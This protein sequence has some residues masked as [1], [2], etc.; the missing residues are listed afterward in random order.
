MTSRIN[1]IYLKKEE[2]LTK[3]KFDNM[4]LEEHKQYKRD[5]FKKISATPQYQE[6]RKQ[7]CEQNKEKL[8][9]K[10]KEW[11]ENNKETINEKRRAKYAEKKEK[12][13]V[14]QQIRPPE[15]YDKRAEKI[16]CCCGCMIRRDNMSKHIK[17]P[18]HE[19]IMKLKNL[20]IQ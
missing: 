19:E 16:P 10:K 15:Y 8:E 12:G 5:Y 6:Y 11:R 3:E 9:V 4:T 18:R 13:E 7:Y 2:H 20:T 1:N 17:T 14:V